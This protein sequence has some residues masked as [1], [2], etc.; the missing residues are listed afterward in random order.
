MEVRLERVVSL[1]KFKGNQKSPGSKC[2]YCGRGTQHQYRPFC[3]QRCAQLDL[4]SW[5]NENYRVPVMEY[6]DIDEF[7]END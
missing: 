3:S 6:D 2:P 7:E 4:G 1:K 5:L